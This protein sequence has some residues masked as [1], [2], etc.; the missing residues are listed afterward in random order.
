MDG[1][2]QEGGTATIQSAGPSAGDPVNLATG[3]EQYEPAADLMI[4]NPIGPSVS[5]S[6][7]YNSLRPVAAYYNSDD[8]GVGWSH[9]YN[10][11]MY[12]PTTNPRYRYQQGSSNS[13]IYPQGNDACGSNLSWDVVLNGVTV[14]SSATT[15]GWSAGNQ[16]DSITL[17]VPSGATIGTG[18]EVRVKVYTSTYLSAFFDVYGST[19]T[20]QVPAGGY[21][22]FSFTG[23]D[24]PASGLTWDIVQGSTTPCNIFK[25]ERMGGYR[26]FC[27]SSAD[28]GTG[29]I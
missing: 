13:Q 12:D 18:Y 3:E 2:G 11:M 5:F 20:P 15:N 27:I 1:G 29:N 4:Y 7:L 10:Y 21:A 23:H 25:P 9:S 16:Q 17:T 26:Q 8:L 22:S 28:G 19:S 14:A 6:R 24:S